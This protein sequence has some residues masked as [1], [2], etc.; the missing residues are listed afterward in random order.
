MSR[1]VA[2]DYQPDGAL[3]RPSFEAAARGVATA[4]MYDV[5]ALLMGAVRNVRR[6]KASDG[7]G[8]SIG[9]V[10]ASSVVSVNWRDDVEQRLVRI[11][12]FGGVSQ[13]GLPAGS[14][15]AS[16]IAGRPDTAEPVEVT[17]LDTLKWTAAY[18][19][20]MAYG[21]I[22]VGVSL[23]DAIGVREGVPHGEP[24]LPR[25]YVR[26]LNGAPMDWLIARDRARLD[27]A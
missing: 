20:L 26:V 2:R 5:E 4:K 6:G 14:I 22:H 13:L 7:D 25:S 11:G 24:L 19:P 21:L 10:L 8:P 27:R 1:H 3:E 16:M 18:A 17:V 12:I 9:E 23:G 15:L